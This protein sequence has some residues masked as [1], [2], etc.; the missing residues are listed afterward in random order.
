MLPVLVHPCGHFTQFIQLRLANPVSA[1]LFNGHQ[2]AIGQY[3]NMKRY[4][5]LAHIKLFGN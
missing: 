4:S 1:F 2:P 3:F 5:L